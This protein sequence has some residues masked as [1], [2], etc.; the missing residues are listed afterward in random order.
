[1]EDLLDLI[2]N[3]EQLNKTVE[4]LERKVYFAQF[5]YDVYECVF[6]SGLPPFDANYHKPGQMRHAVH[7]MHTPLPSAKT[8]MSF[9]RKMVAE[10]REW[11]NITL[12]SIVS[13]GGITAMKGKWVQYE[14]A[15]TGRTYE[16]KDLNGQPTGETKQATAPRY[17]K[18]YNTVDEAETEATE[19]YGNGDNASEPQATPT[20]DRGLAAFQF[21]RFYA[22]QSNGNLEQIAEQITKNAL[23]KEHYWDAEN[24]APNLAHPDVVQLVAELQPEK[25]F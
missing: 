18:L 3:Q 14:F 12:P 2:Q 9:D 6:E 22:T 21:L 5:D 8:D 4:Q 15:P 25:P 19:I 16:A 10:T 23:L 20:Q 11:L 13:L 24:D 1:M 17:L 7:L